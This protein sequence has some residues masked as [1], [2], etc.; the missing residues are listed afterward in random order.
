MDDFNMDDVQ[1]EVTDAVIYEIKHN[2]ELYKRV[3]N[4]NSIQDECTLWAEEHDDMLGE[5]FIG[6]LEMA[7]WKRVKKEL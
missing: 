2:P 7:D 6:E 1:Q 4:A 5:H 3:K